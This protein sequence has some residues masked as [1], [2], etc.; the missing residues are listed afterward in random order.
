MADPQFIGPL[1]IP[2]D[3]RISF[4]KS[5]DLNRFLRPADIWLTVNDPRA[6]SPS[7]IST[8]PKSSVVIG[9]AVVIRPAAAFSP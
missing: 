6:R 7:R 3:A 2:R 4:R 9:V 1:L 5:P 8:A